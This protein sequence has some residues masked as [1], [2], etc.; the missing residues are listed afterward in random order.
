M[1]RR[2]SEISYEEAADGK[3]NDLWGSGGCKVKIVTKVKKSYN[4]AESL[5]LWL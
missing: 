4:G 2:E 1:N 3:N 5:N